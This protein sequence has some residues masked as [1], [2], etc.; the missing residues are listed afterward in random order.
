MTSKTERS[1]KFPLCLNFGSPDRLFGGERIRNFVRSTIIGN[2]VSIITVLHLYYSP[3]VFPLLPPLR[4]PLRT[5][6]LN[7]TAVLCYDFCDPV[8]TARAGN[9]RNPSVPAFPA[10]PNTTLHAGLVPYRS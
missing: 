2:Y 5:Y 9:L 10:K 6:P 1:L 3:F 7:L 8:L 4:L